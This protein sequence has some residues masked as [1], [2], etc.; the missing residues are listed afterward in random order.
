LRLSACSI[1]VL[2]PLQTVPAPARGVDTLPGAT[3]A[4]AGDTDACSWARDLILT[5]DGNA[6]AVDS[7][8]WSEYH[9]AAVMACNYHVTLVDCSLE[10]ME[11][12]GIARGHALNALAPLI[13]ATTENVLKCGPESALTGPIRRGDAATIERHMD[14]LKPAPAETRRL[15]TAAGMRTLSIARRAGLAPD[16]VR[17]V[18]KVLER[19]NP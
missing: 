9:A 11:R 10:L 8:H 5:L 16:K 17:E 13:R 2:H 12:A 1:G 4:Y 3:F 15:Y 6:L 7:E 14:A 19:S 18:A